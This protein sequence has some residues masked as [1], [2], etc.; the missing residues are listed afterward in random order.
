MNFCGKKAVEIVLHFFPSRV[1]TSCC[2]LISDMLLKR[3]HSM[4]LEARGP[5][6]LATCVRESI[7][8]FARSLT[9]WPQLHT[10]NPQQ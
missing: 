7:R 9:L 10:Q 1:C 5:Y 6:V 3:K 8:L 4:G 2:Q